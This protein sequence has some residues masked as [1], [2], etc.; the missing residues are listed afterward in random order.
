LL[1]AIDNELARY[2]SRSTSLKLRLTTTDSAGVLASI[3]PH[4][5]GDHGFVVPSRRE[6]TGLVSLQKLALLMQFGHVRVQRGDNFIMALEEPELHIPPPLQRRLLHSMEALTSQAIITTHSPT[7]AA[8]CKP[9]DLLVVRQTGGTL[10]VMPLLDR[11]LD[12]ND[13]NPVRSLVLGDRQALVDAL[14]HEK[15][16]IPEGKEDH[17]W[18]T[19]ITRM[20][21]TSIT[22]DHAA[23]DFPVQ[24]G[25][26]PTPSA[27]VIDTYK[28]ISGRHPGTV[29]L[30]DG[31]T[32]GNAYANELLAL[33]SPP[34]TIIQLDTDLEIEDVVLWIVAADA[35][36]LL[37]PALV[38]HAVPATVAELRGALKVKEGKARLKNDHQAHDALADALSGSQPCVLRAAELLAELAHVICSKTGPTRL[39]A[40]DLNRSTAKTTL[41][42]LMLHRTGMPSRARQAA[43]RRTI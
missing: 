3:Y 34:A 38:N 12:K 43:A 10:T 28:F 30:V 5:R 1:A 31:D 21:E 27:R 39:F 14:R 35:T 7:I 32:A 20:V 4:Y 9:T 16:L 40:Q 23:F 33:P 2:F 42:R 37:D 29:C 13:S 26:I 18:L 41:W 19:R 6:G 8:A 11:P 17:L 24:V 15:V 36:A 22:T 25:T